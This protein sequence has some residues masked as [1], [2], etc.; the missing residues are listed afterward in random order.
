MIVKSME[1]E[2]LAGTTI[3]E[4]VRCAFTM[5]KNNN[6]CLVVF[7]FNGIRIKVKNG[8]SR[9]PEMIETYYHEALWHN[10]A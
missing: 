3:S 6:D 8:E 4:A 5:S 10:E 1:I 7:G 9:T 2:M